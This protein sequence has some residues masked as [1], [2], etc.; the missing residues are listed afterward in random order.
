MMNEKEKNKK[1]RKCIIR[2]MIIVLII[3][4][5]CI[6]CSKKNDINPVVKINGENEIIRLNEQY[7]PSKI[8]IEEDGKDVT[9]KAKINI[10]NIDIA[11]T[12]EYEV[13]VEYI[14]KNGNKHEKIIIVTVIDDLAPKITLFGDSIIQLSEG[15]KYIEI[16]YE[17]LDNYDGDITEKVEVKNEINTNKIGS[18]IIIYSVRDSSG[19]KIEARRYIEVVKRESNIE[20]PKTPKEENKI[21][22]EKLVLLKKEI[23]STVM[24]AK[25]VIVKLTFNKEVS[26]KESGWLCVGKVCSKTYKDNEISSVTVTDKDKQSITENITI[27]NIDIKAPIITLGLV[28]NEYIEDE[29]INIMDKVSVSDNVT[30]KTNILLTT[31]C[32]KENTIM[33]C[34]DITKY[35]GE[36]VITYIAEDEFGNKSTKDRTYMIYPTLKKEVSD[37]TYSLFGGPIER[38]NLSSLTFDLTTNVVPSGVIGSFDVSSKNNGLIMAWYTDTNNDGLYEVTIGTKNKL[39]ANPDSSYLFSVLYL[40]DPIDFSKLDTSKVTNMSELFKD[41]YF[42]D[43]ILD[44]FNTSNV[45]NMSGMF[46][47]SYFDS[48][49]DLTVLDTSKVTDMSHMFDGSYFPDLVLDDFNTSNVT[50]MSSMFKSSYF[51]T[52]T[53]LDVSNFD[54]KNVTD[55][56]YMFYGMSNTSSID[57]SGFNTS[58]VTNMSNMFSNLAKISTLNVDYFNTENVTDMSYMF[59]N[60]MNLEKLEVLNFNTSNVT[61]MSNMFEGLKKVEELDLS[62]FDTSS[63]VNF[64]SMF[65]NSNALKKLN[66]NNFDT[67]TAENMSRMFEGL[68]IITEL[69][70]VN[71]RTDNVKTMAS[72]FLKMNSLTDLNLSNFNT[73]KVTDMSNMFSFTGNISM[74]DLSHF[75]TN[76]VITMENMFKESKISVLHF[77]FGGANVTNMNAMFYG[78]TNI[79]TLDFSDLDVKKVNK[80]ETMFFN[81]VE[82]TSIKLPYFDTSNVTSFYY[83]FAGT[84]KLKELII[85]SFDTS[86]GTNFNSMFYESGLEVL[87]LSHFNTK[88]ATNMYRM[89]YQ[90]SD[91][92]SLDISNFDTKN[93]IN[94]GSMFRD[95]SNLLSLDVTSFNTSNVTDMSYMFSNL[96][97]ITTLDVTK[98]NTSKV[99]DMS[100][101]FMDDNGI[102]SLD[103]SSFDTGNVMS[104][105]GMFQNMEVLKTLD[106]SQFQFKSGVD[107]S[108]MFLVLPAIESI[109]L[110]SA[111]LT[112]LSSSPTHSFML[113]LVNPTAIFYVKD[114]ASRDFLKN[115]VS[116]TINAVIS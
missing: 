63:V 76:N 44:D 91:L 84:R 98:F 32:K 81:C 101:M 58:N 23:S 61:N 108:Y 33:P 89:F 77:G 103:L 116:S 67:L 56:S 38:Y 37:Y 11:T 36:Y 39:F 80:T 50:N 40:F 114:I 107:V 2:T 82:L 10:Q 104:M 7:N 66:L 28:I 59:S 68:N 87:D 86:L 30:P 17:A 105:L 45:T 54:T 8:R 22:V 25:N 85:P 111:D 109:S 34:A 106:L 92:K 43:L 88:N 19:N 20:T 12:G 4:L 48:P 94:M 46:Q 74:L 73:G 55:M 35:G 15:E 99:T 78:M 26:T 112:V 51:I 18:Y 13:K 69:D 97:K 83:M 21:E 95:S 1:Q 60:I 16:G 93:V 27:E 3:L 96:P 41:S 31:I 64:G 72:M 47:Y 29:L 6:K 110:N 71:F 49:L 42:P 90:M 100:H 79:K 24:S 70:L 65:L 57:V 9:K 75:D 62:L 115:N 14:D 53:S 102:Q 52:S 113:L 5:L